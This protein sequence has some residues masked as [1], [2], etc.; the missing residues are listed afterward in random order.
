MPQ[1]DD[2]PAAKAVRDSQ[3][4]PRGN[5]SSEYEAP[6]NDIERLL[7]DIWQQML[8]VDRVGIHDNFFELGGDSLL[9]IQLTATVNRAGVRMTPK[10]IFEHQT[11]A[12]LAANVGGTP[13]AEIGPGDA[14]K[15][16]GLD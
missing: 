10:Q 16:L 8:G 15:L 2:G 9:N 6:R 7:A 12:E 4:H 11:I 3:A 5:L 13:K 1:A 14:V